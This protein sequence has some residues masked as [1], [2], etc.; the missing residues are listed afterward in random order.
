MCCGTRNQYLPDNTSEPSSSFF[1][2]RDNPKSVSVEKLTHSVS[3]EIPL[4]LWNPKIY[5]HFY[6]RLS[7]VHIL[8]QIN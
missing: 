8:S 5:H 4:L 6:K 3:Q 1:R 2:R 7:S